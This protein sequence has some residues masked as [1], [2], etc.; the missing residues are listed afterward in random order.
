MDFENELRSAL[1]NM[2]DVRNMLSGRVTKSDV[3][4]TSDIQIFDLPKDNDGSI[5]TVG[6]CIDDVINFLEQYDNGGT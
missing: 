3:D 5:F 4:E 6:D 1:F 2:Y